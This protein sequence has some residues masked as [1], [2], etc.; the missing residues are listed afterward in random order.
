MNYKLPFPHSFLHGLQ[1]MN[2]Y[3]DINFEDALI[4]LGPLL[5]FLEGFGVRLADDCSDGVRSQSD[6]DTER[7]GGPSALG[8]DELDYVGILR[9]SVEEVSTTS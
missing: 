2:S 9:S 1:S 4:I 6:V 5:V 3:L 7:L 8:F